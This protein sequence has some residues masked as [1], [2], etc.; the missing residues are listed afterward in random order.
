MLARWIQWA[1]GDARGSRDYAT[2]EALRTAVDQAGLG[3]TA[4]DLV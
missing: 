2:L 1:P 3:R 4:H